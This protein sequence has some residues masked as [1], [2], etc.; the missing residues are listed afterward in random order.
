M[1]LDITLEPIGVEA[2]NI[3]QEWLTDSALQK[4]TKGQVE[5]AG[6]RCLKV[7]LALRRRC[8]DRNLT[9]NIEFINKED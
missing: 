6:D 4:N 8:Y 5:L 9:V 2:G 7:L 1:L 3:F